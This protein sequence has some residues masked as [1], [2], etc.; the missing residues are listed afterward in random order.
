M[1]Y[2]STYGGIGTTGEMLFGDPGQ[3]WGVPNLRHHTEFSFNT[4][5]TTTRSDRAQHPRSLT[6]PPGP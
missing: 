5:P 1:T 6:F 2:D 4:E 3:E